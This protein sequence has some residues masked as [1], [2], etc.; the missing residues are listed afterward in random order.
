MKKI[1]KALT[2]LMMIIL[3][4]IGLVWMKQPNY[5]E[6]SELEKLQALP[7]VNSSERESIVTGVIKYNQRRSYPGYN[8]FANHVNKAY[9]IDME[10]KIVHQWVF[11][12]YPD[13]ELSFIELLD[14]GDVLGI[15]S[16]KGLI[17]LN[18]NSEVIWVKHIN[19]HHDVAM[20]PDGSLM[21]P[22]NSLVKLYNGRIVKFDSLLHLAD[23]GETL[24]E[25]SSFENLK[26]LQ[27]HHL[28]LELDK[29]NYAQVTGI[30]ILNKLIN[31]G[32]DLSRKILFYAYYSTIA[33][34]DRQI[35]LSKSPTQQNQVTKDFKPAKL[36]SN[37]IKR[38]TEAVGKLIGFDSIYDYYHLNTVEILPE[39]PLAIVDKRF[40]AGNLLICSRN[41]NLIFILDKNSKEIVWSWGPG[42][43][44]RPHMPTMLEN[45][46]LLVYDN[47][48]NRGYS[49]I[50][51]LNPM[52]KTIV[53][54]YQAEPVENFYSKLRG[55]NQRLA[56]GNTLIS[57]SNNGRIFEV[58]SDG[59]VVWE[60][61]NF[62]KGKV[63]ARMMRFPEDNINAWLKQ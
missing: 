56:N 41:T 40:Q 29:K 10:G 19:A 44:D 43:L 51:E 8:L 7:Y 27:K 24:S 49:T 35:N 6:S 55:S 4:I 31:G 28:D 59:E 32:L 63:I 50:L 5:Q 21:V 36:P 57:E 46:N 16:E 34:K 45:G 39:N 17:K 61:V 3:I 53:W 26:D 23:T 48:T 33:P 13:G 54:E 52:S 60:F 37:L 42:M 38:I 22:V 14:N 15:Y 2:V 25:W 18:K 11:P 20:M 47:G 12:E 62:E 1:I 30:K 58:T 9:L